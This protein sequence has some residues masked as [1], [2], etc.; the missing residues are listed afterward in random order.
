MSSGC[1]I[2][3]KRNIAQR[4]HFPFLKR[5][6]LFSGHALAPVGPQIG[7]DTAGDKAVAAHAIRA[8]FGRDN[9]GQRAQSRL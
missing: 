2:V 8:C 9:F 5:D 4:F 7:F 6:A 3:R 1:E